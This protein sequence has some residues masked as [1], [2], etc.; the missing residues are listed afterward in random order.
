MIQSLLI[1][2]NRI[3]FGIV[4]FWFWFGGNGEVVAVIVQT[5][6][7]WWIVCELNSFTLTF[8]TSK[9]GDLVVVLD[10]IDAV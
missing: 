7:H 3:L 8:V 1:L 6:C 9:K 2:I 5:E 4:F 10:S